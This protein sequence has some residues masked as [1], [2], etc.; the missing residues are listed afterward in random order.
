MTGIKQKKLAF[1]A[2]FFATLI[3]YTANT[4]PK[5]DVNLESRVKAAFLFNF[6]KFTEWPASMCGSAASPLIFAV[7]GDSPVQRALET[8]TNGKTIN[9]H[10]IEVKHF[11][12]VKEYRA[13]GASHLVYVATPEGARELLEANGTASALIVTDTGEKNSTK[14]VIDFVMEQSKVRFDVDNALARKLK[15]KIS[16]ELLNLARRVS[17]E[18]V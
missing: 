18:S 7:I 5:D 15:I 2:I 6:A 10:P 4:D 9:A 1:T 16:S 3:A 8:M 14:G 12:S 13:S 11:N 17:N